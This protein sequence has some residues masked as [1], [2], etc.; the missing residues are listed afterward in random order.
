MIALCLLLSAAVAV[1]TTGAVGAEPTATGAAVSV[2]TAVDDGTLTVGV[3]ITNH[4]GVSDSYAVEF[5]EDGGTVD[6][7]SVWA[8]PD[9]TVQVTFERAVSDGAS[10]A[11]YVNDVRVER[12]SIAPAT[13]TPDSSWGTSGMAAVA[14]FGVG[15]VAI[16]MSLIRLR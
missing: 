5:T 11:V 7:R 8:P 4:G 2:S 6:S 14:L 13:E 9:G 15:L 1:V 10:Y 16:S 12:V 3:R